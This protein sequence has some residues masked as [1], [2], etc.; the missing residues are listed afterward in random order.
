MRA[1]NPT[2]QLAALTESVPDLE[3]LAREGAR[4]WS[5][6]HGHV[7]AES[8]A[9]AHAAGLLVI[10]WTVNDAGE[11]AALVAVG[12]DGVITDQPDLVAPDGGPRAPSPAQAEAPTT[13]SISF[14]STTRMER[15]ASSFETIG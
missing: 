14:L 15:I 9:R 7:D 13:G 10:P 4:I 11:I 12:V 6:W 5:P 8:L 3:E 1:L 2:I